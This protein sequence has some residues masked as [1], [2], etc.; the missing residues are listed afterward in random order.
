MPA[1]R[2]NTDPDKVCNIRLFSSPRTPGEVPSKLFV[3]V[4]VVYET[5]GKS[6]TTRFAI[7]QRTEALHE[8]EMKHQRE[9]LESTIIV[10]D[11]E[12]RRT[13]VR[14]TML[15]D[16]VATIRTQLSQQ[17]DRYDK[18][19]K[20]HTEARSK[21]VAST[22]KSDEQEKKLKAQAREI[23]NLKVLDDAI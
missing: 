22:R 15:R 7:Q 13:R 23:L 3:W 4:G 2:V 5:A 17:T 14:S 6:L 11:E 16:D 18:L 19:S 10:K 8:A 21:L 12:V 9:A 20:Q 1:K